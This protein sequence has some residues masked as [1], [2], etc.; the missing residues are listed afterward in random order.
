MTMGLPC[1]G[2]NI[3]GTIETID[4]GETGLLVP[5][6]DP[7]AIANAIAALASDPSL[8][9]SMGCKGRIRA[10]ELFSIGNYCR[11]VTAVYGEI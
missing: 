10:R 1:I 7:E 2:T 11:T 5:P 9:E 6:D 8:R 3:G 4:Q